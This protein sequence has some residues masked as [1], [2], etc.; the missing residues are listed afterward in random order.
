LV[1]AHQYQSSPDFELIATATATVI[2]W[3]RTLLIGFRA[4]YNTF[5][6]CAFSVKFVHVAFFYIYIFESVLDYL[7][8]ILILPNVNV[9]S[10]YADL[11]LGVSYIDLIA[12]QILS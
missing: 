7:L 6:I 2:F 10:F 4:D 5:L 1:I 12:S 11:L 8:F 3:L 9:T